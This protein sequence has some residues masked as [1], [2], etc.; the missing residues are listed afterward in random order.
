MTSQ[1][2]ISFARGAPSLDIV[3][4]DG[5]KAAA[6]RAFDAD[7]AGVTAYG[8]SVGYP[9]LRKWIADKHGV[10]AGPGAGHQR[11][12]AGR[13]VPLRAPGPRRRRRG[14]GEA[15]LRPDAA[16]PAQPGR[17]GAPG[18]ARPTTAST[19]TSCASCWSRGSGPKL[20]HIIPNYQNPAG[21]T[22]SLDKRRA[23]LDLA[24][25]VR[26]H[27]LRGRP[28]RR[29]PVPRRARC[30]RCCRWTTRRTWSCTPA[31]SPRRSARACGSATWSARPALIADDRQDAPPTSTSRPAWCPRRSSTSSASPA[32]STGRSRPSAPRSAS[33]P[34]L[35]A[36]A[37]RKHIPGV[38]FTEPDGGYF[39]WVELPDD[40]DVDKLVAGGRRARAWPSSRAATSCSRAAGTRCGWRTRRSPPTRSTRACAG[41]PRRSTDVRAVDLSVTDNRTVMFAAIPRRSA[42]GSQLRA[43]R[44][45]S[46]SARADITPAPTAPGGSPAPPPTRGRPTR[47]PAASTA[48]HL[49]RGVAST[50]GRRAR[51]G[52]RWPMTETAGGDRAL[53]RA[54]DRTGPRD[55]PDARHAAGRR[56]TPPPRRP[57]DGTRDRRLRRCTSTACASP[58]SWHYAEA[59]AAA[60]EHDER[61]SSGSACT[62]RP[63][64]EL[65]DIAETFGLHELAV[66]DAVKA[67]P[68]AQAGAYGDMTFLRRCAPPGTS[69]TTS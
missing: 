63:R 64:A 11:L 15:D 44:S 29:H 53:P 18:H 67:E 66:E 68:A 22:L 43:Q 1:Q 5:L 2:L 56:P 62:S 24:A 19:S 50:A 69:S 30:R 52:R 38:R 33:G 34:R 37:L 41:W 59:L 13:R 60:R 46:R 12:A 25:R 40:V 6:V 26:V 7:P 51:E 39:L 31:R 48:V 9:P 42:G 57:A 61:A 47:C 45:R 32:T 23:L 58:A 20:A 10:D 4:V 65:A 16:Q 54:L 35:L 49:R 27:D 8:T 14:G 21:V 55:E 3:D 17:Q 36:E 28:V